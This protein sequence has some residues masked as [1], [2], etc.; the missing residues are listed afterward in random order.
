MTPTC[1]FSPYAPATVVSGFHPVRQVTI[2]YGGTPSAIAHARA[3]SWPKVL[4]FLD[5]HVKTPVLAV[6]GLPL[7]LTAH[8]FNVL[9]Y[10]VERPSRAITRR[11]L[12]EAALPASG[13]RSERTVDSHVARIRRKLG[14]APRSPGDLQAEL[15][16]IGELNASTL[17]EMRA[18]IF[19]LRPEALAEEGLV[20]ALTKHAAAV[21]ARRR[22]TGSTRAN[23]ASA[24]RPKKKTP[25]SSG[26]CQNP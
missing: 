15:D 4:Q 6:A 18:A 11:Q 5:V 21:S 1:A 14:P 25:V 2:N 17:A 24:S 26:P 13:D 20:A 8:E 3:D 19:A 10:L 22:S 16:R 23:I 12:A 7:G 9:L